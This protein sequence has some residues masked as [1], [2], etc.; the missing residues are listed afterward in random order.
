[1]ADPNPKQNQQTKPAGPS[2]DTQAQPAQGN[3]PQ[4]PSQGQTGGLTRRSAQPSSLAPASNPFVLMRQLADEMD[5][6][7]ETFGFGR[8][9]FGFPSLWEGLA[10]GG[11]SAAQSQTAAW[12]PQVEVFEKDGRLIVRAEVPGLKK[13]DLKVELT[14]EALIIQGE[15]KRE[16]EDKGDG[17]Y[18]SERS[19]GR[20]YRAIPLP[21]GAS[22]EGATATFRDGVL[23]VSLQAPRREEERAKQIPVQ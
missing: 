1:M 23:E 2:A 7:F 20:F 19:Y 13:E 6:V 15:R 17:F 3:Q 10:S 12:A 11:T 16:H 21:E 4:P 22:A 14:D 8:S 9:R 5:R 18:R